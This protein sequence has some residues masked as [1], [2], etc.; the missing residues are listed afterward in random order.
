MPGLTGEKVRRFAA[1][2][3]QYASYHQYVEI[4]LIFHR[5][6]NY[7]ANRIFLLKFRPT[8]RFASDVENINDTGMLEK[9][10]FRRKS[11]PGL[12]SIDV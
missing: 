10:L 7:E 11:W 2:S 9:Y 5:A 1:G 8:E 3:M 4:I 12:C 6:K